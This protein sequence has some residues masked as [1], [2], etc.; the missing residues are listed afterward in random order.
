MTATLSQAA[1]ETWGWRIPFLL[2]LLIGPVG[3]WIRR[4]LRETEAF[5]TAHAQ[6][7]AGRAMT[8]LLSSHL[9]EVFIVL[10]LSVCGT[11]AFY[12]ILI[13]M[14]TFASKTLGL[15]LTDA[16]V[17][18][19]IAVAVMTLL[20]PLFGAL[21]D[22]IGRRPILIAATLGLLASLYP[23]FSALHDAPSFGRLLFTQVLLCT[24]IGAFFGPI[25][26]TVAEQLPIQVRSTGLA[27]GYNLAVMIF[28]GF[29]QFIVTW[30]I[31]QTHQPI[32]PV[33]YVMF[34]AAVGLASALFVKE[35]GPEDGPEDGPADGPTQTAA[36]PR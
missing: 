25:S 26:A 30:L 34:A 1:L 3:L 29:A 24:L 5:S 10:G 32:A 16:F 7:P 22:R 27:L 35:Q 9:R 23:L 2:G 19:T 28:G 14:P 11:V 4:N 18:Q 8:G 13:Y 31:A 20:V 36:A 12:V 21:S 33:F 15:A 6:A 17:A